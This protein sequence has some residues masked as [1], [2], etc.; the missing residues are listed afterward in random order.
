MTAFD[1]KGKLDQ[2]LGAGGSFLTFAYG[3]RDRETPLAKFS[4]GRSCGFR[5]QPGWP[6]TGFL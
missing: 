5:S 2:L 1:P 4:N 3:S 6:A